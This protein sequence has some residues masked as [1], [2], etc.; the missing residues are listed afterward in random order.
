MMEC[1]NTKHNNK[2]M[3]TTQSTVLALEK[4]N[5]QIVISTVCVSLLQHC[6]VGNL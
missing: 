2:K 1:K 3:L 5:N 6:K 4:T